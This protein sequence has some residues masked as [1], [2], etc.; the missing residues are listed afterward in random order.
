MTPDNLEL[1][2][3]ALEQPPIAGVI[4][5]LMADTWKSS[6]TAENTEANRHSGK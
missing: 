3:A 6:S 5:H 4:F 2:N 1:F